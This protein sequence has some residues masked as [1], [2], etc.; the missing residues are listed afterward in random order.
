MRAQEVPQGGKAPTQK[1]LT[2]PY[3]GSNG[4]GDAD[5]K[6]AP[7]VKPS[8]T[9]ELRAKFWRAQVESTVAQAQAEKTRAALQAIIVAMQ[10]ACGDEQLIAGQDGEP[11]CQAK[12][13]EKSGIQ[14]PPAYST[15]DTAKPEAAKN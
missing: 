8:V 2:A 10:K 12:P 1:D 9:T 14:A 3:R 13:A 4:A 5:I 7:Q 11:T 15:K 6:N